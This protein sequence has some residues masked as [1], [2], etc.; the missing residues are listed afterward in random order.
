MPKL[1]AVEEEEERAFALFHRKLKLI[2]LAT[3]ELIHSETGDF[4]RKQ[5]QQGDQIS[6]EKKI[7]QNVS[8]PIFCNLMNNFYRGKKQPKN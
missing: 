2:S 8:Q 4:V 1:M 7:A 5:S 3:L 6:L